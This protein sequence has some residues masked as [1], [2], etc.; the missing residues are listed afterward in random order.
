MAIARDTFL[1]R[2]TQNNN[3]WSASYTVTGSS[4][5]LVVFAEN[6]SSTPTATSATYNGVAMTLVDAVGSVVGGFSQTSFILVNPATGANTLTVNFSE[7]SNHSITAESYTGV[8]S[9]GSTGG[10]DSHNTASWTASGGDKSI[11]TTTVANNAWIAVYLRTDSGSYAAGTNVST[12]DNVANIALMGDTNSAITPA[13]ATTQTFTNSSGVPSGFI[14]SVGL[15]P[16]VAAG[17]V[18]SVINDNMLIR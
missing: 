4:P 15:T 1:A 9:G 5:T 13:G 11:V 6:G 7:S 10:A 3:A 18:V 16:A 14:L 2:T 12:Q 8:G 17:A